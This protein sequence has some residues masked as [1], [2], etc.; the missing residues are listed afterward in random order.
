MTVDPSVVPGL[1]FL[2][3]ELTVLAA[4]GYVV[5]R[6]ALRETDQRVA[7]AQGLVVGP[8]I[9]GVV[10][11][12][13]MY[14]IP[15]MAGAVAGWIFV[16]AL[17]AVLIWRAPKPVRPRLRAAAG[18]ALIALA[19]FWIALASRQLAT[20]PDAAIHLGMAASIREG[21][22]PPEIPWN[23][24]MP[25]PYHYG[26]NLLRGLLA[27]P[28]GPD[29]A[30]VAELLG[31][32]AW[33]SLSLVVVTALLRRVSAFAVLIAAPLLLTAGGWT[34]M[35]NEPFSIV[36][37]PV[38]TGI[39]SAGLRAS[40]TGI[41]WPSA[42]LPR[43]LDHDSLPNIWRLSFTLSYALAFVVLARAAHA[44]RRSWLSVMTL[45]VLVGF[46]GLL[47]TSLAPI[48]FVLW[49]GL[50]AVWLIQSRRA[51]FAHRS[52]VVRSALG[53]VLAAL[54]LVVANGYL[55]RILTDSVALQ[56]LSLG[57]NERLGGWRLLGTLDRL[58]GGVGILGLGP[59][60]VAGAAMLL[61]RRNR[62]V[63]ALA[64][65]TGMLLLASLPLNYEPQP[66]D[67]VRIEGHA[68]NFALFA[69]LIALGVRLAA[70]R[71]ARWRYAAGALIAPLIIWPAI[72]GTV[73]DLGPT[74]GNGIEVANAPTGFEWFEGRFSVAGG[75]SD[76]IAAYIRNHTA[77]DAR[78]FS[79]TPY[80]M[81]FA[82]GRSNASGIVGH[83]HQQKTIGPEHR[84]V[85]RYLEPSAVR[86]LGIGYVHAPDEWVESL[87]DE[88]VERLN[89][90]RLFE[91]LVRDTSESLYR[92]LPAFLTLDPPPA[93]G[94]Y[95]ALRRAIPASTTV[96][97]PRVFE[98]T[99]ST[100]VA[101]ALSHTQ[102]LGA[103]GVASLHFRTPWQAEPLGEHDPD[104]II[105]GAR[106]VPWV[107]PPAARQPIWWNDETAVYAL[108]GAV[109]PITPLRDEPFPF[110]VRVSDVRAA[111]GRIAFT[112]TFDDRAPER[113]T[114]QDWLL[115]A[116]DNSRYGFPTPILSDGRLP[117]TTMWFDSYLNPGKGT[118]SFSYEFNFL[119]P[120]LAIR[121]ERGVLKPLDRSEAA[122]GSGRYVLAVR[123]RHEYKPNYWRDVAIIP[124]LKITAS[125]TGEVSYQVY[126]EAGG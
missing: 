110:S 47:A 44:G 24:G 45:A 106:F 8:A 96:F 93:P 9:W 56:G 14:A 55:I 84:D 91:L 73:R 27:P 58:P 57:W 94:S 68:R 90:P 13:V 11:N 100:R 121:R 123:L 78:V 111:D 22:F 86:R 1:L 81:T 53:I 43:N 105:T 115:I 75:P 37:I 117:A 124:V 77:I 125:E 7:L 120:S 95:E 38:P 23:P 51:G 59:L 12:L 72:A 54:L 3:A 21:G 83:L 82:T 60:A 52:D 32:Y 41:Y 89:D 74:I 103:I 30:F 46:V 67:I 49:A 122:L 114:G 36:E 76:R 80:R 102:L 107:F 101:Q 35:F 29:L 92:V 20:I 116:L 2:L 10:V 39:P 85:L 18:F 48:V 66:A 97:T 33:M 98:S 87:P 6:T 126:E 19:L 79:T 65:G 118:S 26:V 17:A 25:A 112:A 109:E 61:A 108:D 28:S 64:A 4:V 31:A 5:V 113:W 88:A 62:L 40:L 15:G 70:L 50:E 71:S 34:L 99:S 69:L 16:L 119:A 104:L 63:Q 42:E